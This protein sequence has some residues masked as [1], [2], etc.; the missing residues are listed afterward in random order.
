[1]PEKQFNKYESQVFW[2]KCREA[3]YGD[4]TL[5][6]EK[7]TTQFKVTLP[8]APKYIPEKAECPCCGALGE[9]II[10]TAPAA[11]RDSTH[12]ARFWGN[13]E[14]RKRY[15]EEFQKKEIEESQKRLEGKTGISPYSKYDIDYEYFEQEGTLKRVSDKKAIERV[16]RSQDVAKSV[17]NELQPEELAVIGKRDNG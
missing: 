12:S 2:F 7:G 3:I 15:A 4:C 13:D 14:N 11:L 9:V 6:A 10:N 1:M 8:E 17:E 5:I 16:K